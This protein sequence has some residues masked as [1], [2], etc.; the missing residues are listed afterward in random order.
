MNDLEEMRIGI[1]L[2][3]EIF[4]AFTQVAGGT[5]DRSHRLLAA[6]N[7]SV[8]NLQ[9]E[10]A[11]DT[12]IFCLCKHDHA[13]LMDCFRCGAETALLSYSVS[14]RSTSNRQAPLLI[15]EVV[16]AIVQEREQQLR[17]SFRRL[18]DDHGSG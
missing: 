11:I 12:Y 7:H 5:E 13:N 1:M 2:A 4:P 14:P 8:A 9:N 16:Y 6:F 3:T 18:G 17:D 10:S 15:A